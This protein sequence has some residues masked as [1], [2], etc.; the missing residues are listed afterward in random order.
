MD[1]CSG[2]SS[3]LF[4]PACVFDKGKALLRARAVE[5]T[6]NLNP[7]SLFRRTTTQ[8]CI[9]PST[10]TRT[11]PVSIWWTSSCKTLTGSSVS[12]LQS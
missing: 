5:M 10:R 8:R 6:Q 12:I 4:V 2:S 7:V 9:S 3:T 11:A 1:P